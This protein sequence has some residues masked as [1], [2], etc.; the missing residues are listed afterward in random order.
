MVAHSQSQLLKCLHGVQ[1]RGGV[2][3]QNLHLVSVAHQRAADQFVQQGLLSQV[4][5]ILVF[6]P[7]SIFLL[8]QQ[9]VAC[10]G[11]QTAAMMVIR[12]RAAEVVS[13]DRNE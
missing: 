2:P 7:A 1:R 5:F 4:H 12:E 13:G 3:L 10:T 9:N 6:P 11:G 8:L